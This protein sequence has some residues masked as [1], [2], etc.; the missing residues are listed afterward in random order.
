VAF[1][2]FD[3]PY[4]LFIDGTW[5][6]SSTGETFQCFDPYESKPW[7]QVPL[8]SELD[9]DRAVRAARQ[10]FDEG[11]WPEV[12][13]KQRADL[14]RR[15]ADLIDQHADELAHIQVHENGKLLAEMG[16][17]VRGLSAHARFCAGLAEQVHGYTVVPSVPNMTAY[18]TREPVGVVAAVTPWNSPLSLLGWKLFPA[19]AVGCTI[20]IKPS[21]ITPVST[22]RLAELCQ[23]AGYPDGVVNVV[24][25]PGAPTGKALIEHAGVDKIAFTGSTA[26]G[27]MMAHAAAER[28]GR[29][30]LELG[31]KSPSIIFPDADLENAVHGVMGGIFAATGQTCLAGSRVLVHK[32]VHDDVVGLLADRTRALKLG[33]P[34]E[35]DSDVGPLSCPPQYKKVLGCIDSGV[36]EG[37]TIV[38]GGVHPEQPTDLATGLF[39]EP[40][41][42]ADV[43]NSSQLAQTEIFGPVAS[44]I[45]FEDEDQ[46]VTIAN[47][48]P[49]GLAGAVW[50][51]DVGRAHRLVR[52]IRAGT[53]WVNTYR[54]GAYTVPFGGFK[55]SGLGREVGLDALDDYTEIKSV[56]IDHGN[57]QQFGRRR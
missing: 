26:V 28:I 57:V 6:P 22:L 29:V 1:D 10:A 52:R 3:R 30:S 38:T 21:E 20:V 37:A 17:G 40:T 49:Y 11:G 7:G 42:F 18:T 25:G 36:A 50:T 24:T 34:L 45:R 32:D 15:L 33:D 41:V 13:P 39:V 23:E 31:G 14:L 12:L 46:A 9:V 16:P 4:S 51:Q 48:V 2:E 27:R 54:V 19:L 53:V 56:W 35:R 5:V 47:D 44:V 43:E 8:A 55:Q